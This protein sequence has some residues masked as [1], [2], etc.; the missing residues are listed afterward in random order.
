MSEMTKSDK[1]HHLYEYEI[2][3]ILS[4]KPHFEINVHLWF[5][6]KDKMECSVQYLQYSPTMPPT[7]RKG[8]ELF[9]NINIAT[10]P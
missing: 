7:P 5:E 10:T 8:S 1:I 3:E 2:K 4:F 6:R 9:L